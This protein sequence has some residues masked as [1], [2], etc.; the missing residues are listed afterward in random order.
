[1]KEKDVIEIMRDHI[2]KQFPK[3]CKCCGKRYNSFAEF[4]RNT[5]PVGKPMSYDAEIG[6]WKPVRPIGTIGMA[7]CSCG[8]TLVLT[9]KGMN[10]ITLW[11]L[12]NWVRNEAQKRGITVS[13]LLVELRRTIDI[14]V[15]Q[16]ESKKIEN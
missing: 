2:S 9:S 10:L 15:L 4:V 7:N 14:G 3:E 13:D 16:D 8:S 11:K 6:D 5:T 1:M 12:M